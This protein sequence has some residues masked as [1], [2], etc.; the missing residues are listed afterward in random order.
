MF[1]TEKAEMDQ[2]VKKNKEMYRALADTDT[3]EDD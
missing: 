1:E 2:D 3:N